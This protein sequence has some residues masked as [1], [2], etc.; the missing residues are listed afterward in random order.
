MAGGKFKK[1]GLTGVSVGLYIQ[2]IHPLSQYRIFRMLY[3][4]NIKGT[5]PKDYSGYDIKQGLL[6]ASV[7]KGKQIILHLKIQK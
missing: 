6:K 2:N 4:F 3:Y 1:F 7:K 5:A